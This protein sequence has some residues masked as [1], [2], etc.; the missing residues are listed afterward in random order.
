MRLALLSTVAEASRAAANGGLSDEITAGFRQAFG[1]SPG[2]DEAETW[3]TTLPL[4]LRVAAAEVP[5]DC[6]V[7]VEYGLPFNDQR[8]DLTVV[9][10][11]GG[12]PAV[13]VMEL[14][15]WES[16]KASERLEHFV[17]VGGGLT[18]HP[19]YQVLNYMGKLANF[20]SFGPS[21]DIG[22]SAIIAD[23][24]PSRH[25]S[26]FGARFARLLSSA[27][28][29]VAPELQ[30]LA[31]ALR[32]NLPEGPQQTWVQSLVSGTY[33]Q[34]ARL[35]ETLRDKQEALVARASDVIAACGWGLSKD[36]LRVRD[37]VVTAI[38][39]GER[40]VI[41]VSGGPGSGKSLLALHAFL[42]AF[43]LG[44]R[45]V[46]AVRNNRLNAALREIFR[47]EVVGAQGAIKY[48]STSGR[49][50]VEDGSAPIADVVVCDE[51]QRL[52]LS[53]PNVLRRAPTVVIFFDDKQVLNLGER[54]T[55]EGL[56][57]ACDEIGVQPRFYTLPTPHR[58]RGGQAY[59]SWVDSLLEDPSAALQ[60]SRDWSRDYDLVVVSHP[61][62]VRS[63]LRRQT[64]R[65]GLLASFTRA[66]GRDGGG[67]PRDLG[68]VRVPEVQPP[69]RWL[70]EPRTEYVPFYLEGKSNDLSTCA[71]IYGCQGFELDYTGLFWGNDFVIR[72]GRWVIGKPEDCYDKAPGTRSLSRLMREEPS[73]ALVLLRNR[74]R[75]LL[76]RGI[77]GTVVFCEDDETRA[78]L[79]QA[80]G[81]K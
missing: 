32:E 31:T 37:E 30:G 74:Y 5:P 44:R 62:E 81:S 46:L 20:H 68:R 14:K 24:G 71:S 69:V 8:I 21:L 65:V 55:R 16:S 27:P 9:G 15:R 73:T 29:F 18:P 12:K 72:K 66:S 43:G 53:T 11:K 45:A 47:S 42:G 13:H 36:Q 75:I 79:G 23:G 52:A 22:G 4:V 25:H 59:L 64:G 28:L 61:E 80:I 77:F 48:F 33:S 38:R 70:M 3:R 35:L 2:E 50:G 39:E 10:G 49:A 41:C 58:C 19:S 78:F 67:N 57:Q 7:L 40:A 54:G 51:G 60:R 17:E 1:R 76:T 56:A 6:A 26:L 34:S 63:W